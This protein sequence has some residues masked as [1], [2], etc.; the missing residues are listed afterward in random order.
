MYEIGLTR[1]ME[2]S[3]ELIRCVVFV[4]AFA[5]Q[6][7]HA[8]NFETV[9]GKMRGANI[10]VRWRARVDTRYSFKPLLFYFIICGDSVKA[11]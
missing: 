8:G 6:I 2:I 4:V 9:S 10:Q 3:T 7:C 5:S 1:T 11:Y